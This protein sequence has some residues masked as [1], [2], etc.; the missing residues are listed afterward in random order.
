VAAFPLAPF[1]A[2]INNVF[3]IRFD[4]YK[5]IVTTRRPVPEQARNIGVWLVGSN[6]CNARDSLNLNLPADNH[7]HDLQC[8]GPLQ[9]LRHCLHL[10]L[11][12]A[13]TFGHHQLAI[14]T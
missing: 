1:F 5:F 4:A 13:F 7:Q 3:E 9:R 6:M 12:E 14:N 2:L 8:G 11:C 10:R